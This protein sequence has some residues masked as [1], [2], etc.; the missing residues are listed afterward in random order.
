M[1]AAAALLLML[2]GAAAGDTLPEGQL[3]MAVIGD[4]E[5][6]RV[7]YL[8]PWR[9]PQ[10]AEPPPLPAPPDPLAVPPPAAE[11]GQAPIIPASPRE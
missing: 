3:G 4:R 5:L 2:A 8:L 6:P 9:A 7:L 11:G 1:R 10:P